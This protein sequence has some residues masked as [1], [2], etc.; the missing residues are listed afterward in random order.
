MKYF[1]CEICGNLV[2]L[3]DEGGGELVCCGEPMKELVPKSNDV[4]TEKH[5][6]VV[7]KE[8]NKITVNVGSVEHPMTPEHYIEWISILYNNKTQLVKLEPVSKPT[9]TFTVEEEFEFIEIYSYCNVHG[10][11]KIKVESL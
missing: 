11:W 7:T 5:L 1:L 3:I 9:A 6:P 2:A 8:G 4:G 10:L